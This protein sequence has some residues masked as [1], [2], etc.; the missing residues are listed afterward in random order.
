MLRHLTVATLSLALLAPAYADTYKDP[1]GRFQMMIPSGWASVD[2]PD[3]KA[4]TFVLGNRQT[5]IPAY[6][7]GLFM[8]TP[9]SRNRS[10][11]DINEE[12][13]GQMTPEFWRE[14]M[15]SASDSKLAMKIETS[16]SRT[17]SG[18]SIHHAVY[19]ASSPG[20]ANGPV[21]KGKMEM[22]FVPGAMHTVT[23]STKDV[24]Y[25]TVS[26]DFET[27]LTSYDP[28]ADVLVSSL[29]RPAPSV[30]TMYEKVNYTGAARV[31]SQD[32]PNLAAAG[33]PTLSASLSVDGAEP[34]Q[35]CVGAGFTGA[36]RTV[37]GAQS[38]G[39]GPLAI[40]S[41]RRLSGKIGFGNFATTAI[42]RTFHNPA[43]NKALQR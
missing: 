30:L 34:W 31:L 26:T 9:P 15:K 6:C 18:R 42:R 36:C 5:D 12:V 40:G 3:R 37:V 24:D 2:V 43:M 22:H 1:D 17:Q 10:Q 32:T 19:T 4:L 20:D 14:A 29:E 41:A 8:D 11:A 25:P 35:V 33:W 16:G 39:R 28:R 27:I 38:A 13:N 7:L 23:C 21:L